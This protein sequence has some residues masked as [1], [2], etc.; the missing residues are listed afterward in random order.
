MPDAGDEVEDITH[1][2]AGVDLW[3]EIR[4]KDPLCGIM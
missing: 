4:D 2:L 1:V 3:P